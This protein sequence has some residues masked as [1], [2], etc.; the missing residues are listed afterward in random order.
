MRST[1]AHSSGVEADVELGS[2]Q[3]Q[4]DGEEQPRVH[5]RAAAAGDVAEV[6]DR[7]FRPPELAQ[8][9]LHDLLVLVALGISLVFPGTSYLS[10]FV[11]VLVGPVEVVIRRVT[12]R[13]ATS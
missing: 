11:V 6:E 2:A 13:H 8:E 3:A 10:L 9:A 4:G 7:P 5:L 1:A 12:C